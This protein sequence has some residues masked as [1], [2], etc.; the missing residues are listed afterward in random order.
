MKATWIF[1][2][3]FLTLAALLVAPATAS[4]DIVIGAPADLAN[5]NCYPFGCD[6]SDWG[7]E[8]QQ[9][10]AASD[11]SGPIT[12]TDLAFYNT[13]DPGGEPDTGTFTISLSTTSAAVDGLNLSD[14][15]ANIGPD[16]T[17]VYSG[18][19]PALSGG[20]L[21]ID[22][23]TP[24]TYNPENGNLLINIYS[25]DASTSSTPLY[26]DARNGTAT[27]QF[28]RAYSG[29]PDGIF[30]ADYGLVTGFSTGSGVIPEPSTWAMMLIGF[31]GLGFA[32]YRASRKGA[33]AE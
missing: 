33:L 7:P 31:A 10:Y 15:A 19:L 11:F 26:L 17:Q 23:S 22:L 16:N 1:G 9:V 21:Q 24:F 6:V 13:Q 30:S 25:T 14:L 4:A 5:G 29:D 18:S 28:S 3:G 32:G 27:G 20:V 12:I 2:A 8:Y